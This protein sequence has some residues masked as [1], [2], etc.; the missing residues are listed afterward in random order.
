M[1]CDRAM[2]SRRPFGAQGIALTVALGL[3]ALAACGD[4]APSGVTSPPGANDGGADAASIPLCVD[5]KP[6]AA[7]PPEPYELASL[8]TVP[9][10]LSFESAEGPIAIESFFEPC[11]PRSRVLVVRSSAAWC[12]PCLWQAAHTKRFLEDPRF[13]ER[14]V[15]LDLLVADAEN[16]PPTLGAA[17]A[18]REKLDVTGTKVAIDADYT[19]RPTI[20]GRAPLPEYVF[21][22]TRT[23][24]VLSTLNDPDPH[25]LAERIEVEL[26]DLDKTPRPKLK[27][28]PLI[29]G[30][31]TENE[32]DLIRGMKLGDLA[33]PPDPTNEYADAAGAVAFGK[34]LFSDLGLSPSGTVS[35]AKC[36]DTNLGLADGLPQST[37]IAKVD[38]N[39]PAIALSA[40]ARW[41]FW[42]GHADTLWMQALAPFEDAKEFGGSRLFVAKQIAQ[43][44]ATQYGEVFGTKYPLPDL[45]ALPDNGKPGDAAYDALAQDDKD[46]VTRIYVN[47]G[48]AIAAFERG[49][50]VKPNA[51]DRY[52]DGDLA[53]LPPEAKHVLTIFLRNG[54]VQCHWGPRLTDDAFHTLRFP[55]GRQDS[56]A[57]RGREEGL[58]KLAASEFL[59]S[60]KWSDA[61]NQAKP[62]AVDSP[63]MLGAFKTPTLRGLPTSAP[64][65]HGGS[66][67]TLLDVSKH[68]G[69]R[70]IDH[71][72]SSAI[73]TTEQW[74]PNF[75]ANAQGELPKLLELLTGEV[76]LP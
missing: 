7:Y 37:G 31:F 60:S 49:M 1:L 28:P 53:A 47:V 29:D 20:L 54:C 74:V 59:A 13:A 58:V 57:D 39:S 3:G 2:V 34:A 14:L 18:W 9:P 25:S 11:A 55:T 26:A 21:I 50:R 43:R 19:F 76:V 23:M 42:D 61:P 72:A 12:G 73:G 48:K 71:A 67:P 33:P 32:M 62:F 44:Y 75:D 69:T 65:G 38:R 22:D 66:L 35:C 51:L 36:H 45:S 56:A 5:G 52:A 64:Y 10:G 41:Q 15:L 8:G 63:T 17:A 4:D 40:H 27:A 24:R 6:T 16:L 68:Y 30:H 46:K 70:G